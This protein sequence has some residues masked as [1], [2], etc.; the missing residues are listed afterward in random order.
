MKRESSVRPAGKAQV[1]F[2]IVPKLLLGIL[3]PLFV[4]LIIISIFLGL[5]GSKTVN[6]IMGAELDAEAKSAA[7]QVEAFFERYYGVSECL[8]STQITRDTTTEVTEGSIVA[9]RLYGSLLETLKLIQQD[10]AEDIDFVWLANLQT[11]EILQNDGTIFDRTQVDYSTRSWYKYVME[12]QDT[13]T[14]EVYTGANTDDLMVTVASPVFSNGDLVGI[15]GIDLNMGSLTQKLSSVT[16]GTSGYI[17]LYDSSNQIVYHPDDSVINTNAVDAN[18]SDNMLNAI[19]NKENMAAT[20]YTRSGT[21]YYG[22]TSSVASIGY[23]I[24]GVMPVS[25]YTAHTSAI[26]RILLIGMIGCA[27]LLTAICVFIALSIT[28]PLKHLNVAVGKLAEGELDVAVDTHGRDEVAVVGCNVVRIVERLKEYILYIDEISAVLHQIGNGDLVFTL[29]QEYV[30][31]FSKIKEALLSIRSTLTETLT[32]IAQSADQVKA[33][34]EQLASGAQSLAQGATEQ[35]SS[36]EELSATVQDLSGQ[37]I[38]EAQNAVEAEKFLEQ[39]KDEV[40]KSNAQMDA[41][42]KAME[43]ISVHSTAIR[44]ITKTIDDIAFQTNLLALNAAVEAAR[45]GT[46]G[47]GFAV[48]ADEVRN[49]AGKSADAAKRTNEL[50]ENSASAVEH[51][52][53]LTKLTADSLTVVA[54]KT[55]QVVETMQAVATAYH[56][57]ADKLSEISRGVD[58]IANVVQ[59]NSATAEES[60]AASEE[61]SGQASMMHQQVAQFKLDQDIWQV[62]QQVG[63][64]QTTFENLNETGKY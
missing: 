9:H 46:A 30:G 29:Q 17:T 21:E 54:D 63:A 60:A 48:V 42:R 22:S 12:K 28:R 43:D 58:Q 40:E 35:A 47:K 57:Q 15:V 59:T 19:V 31:D 10:N 13:I 7:S 55:K 44:S 52:E 50:I 8:A 24:L 5:Q 49:L 14:T 38:A 37:A 33:G 34:S 16:V 2:G 53:E 41:M 27:I 23:T 56:K 61:L 6:E 11:G 3:I 32:S 36:V 1:K 25:E 18:Y 4:V 51:G 62:P 39:I 20:L 26:L 64:A 45:A